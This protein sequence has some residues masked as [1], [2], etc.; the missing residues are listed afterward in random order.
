MRSGDLNM[1]FLALTFFA[2]VEYA[3]KLILPHVPF[4]DMYYVA[5]AGI[6]FVVLLC[7]VQCE[8]SPLMEDLVKLT[9]VQLVF[10]FIGWCLYALYVPAF[11]YDVSIHC[12]VVATFMRILWV[13]KDDGNHSLYPRRMLV[14]P[15][16]KLR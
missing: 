14:S 4:D 3:A 10:Q 15:H 9:F 8:K 13:G 11:F 16:L 2:L 1:R 7:L 12:I 5:C 6:N